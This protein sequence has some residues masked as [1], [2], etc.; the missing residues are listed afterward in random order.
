MDSQTVHTSVN[1]PKAATGI[2]L[3]DQVAADNPSAPSGPA[4]ASPQVIAITQHP[5]RVPGTDRKGP[6]ST[7]GLVVVTA[8]G[9]SREW[10]RAP[11]QP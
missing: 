10:C 5:A 7:Q 2:T 4:S 8:S 11:R 1:A 9:P 3:L 6:A